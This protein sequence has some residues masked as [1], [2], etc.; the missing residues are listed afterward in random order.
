MTTTF[1]T[2]L[3]VTYISIG[4]AAVYMSFI[5]SKKVNTQLV[6]LQMKK[7]IFSFHCFGELDSS[8]TFS[9]PNI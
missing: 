6:P 9:M 1:F 2:L 4:E 8:T 7:L 3:F 5:L